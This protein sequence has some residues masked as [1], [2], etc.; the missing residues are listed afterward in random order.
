MIA[1]HYFLNL[2]DNKHKVHL[3]YREIW[4]WRIENKYRNR[5]NKI[6]LKKKKML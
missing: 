6:I 1:K 4:K 3:K 5:M 2:F